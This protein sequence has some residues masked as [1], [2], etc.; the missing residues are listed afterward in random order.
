[1]KN[2]AGQTFYPKYL[3]KR[4]HCF[5][6]PIGCGK[7]I[8]IQEGPYRVPRGEGVEYETIAGFG[9]MCYVSSFEAVALANSLC[10]RYGLDTISTSAVIAFGMELFERGI[11]SL[12][13]TGGIELR[14]GNADAMLDMIHQIAHRQGLGAILAGGVREAARRIG[15]GAEQ[16]AIHVKG[17]EVAYHDPRAF[18]SMAVNYATGVR[19]ACHLEAAT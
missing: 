14:F 7:E 19:G 4:T 18:F 5:A 15:K 12:E 16:Y 1:V 6:C 3:Q 11:L 9:G 17:L 8:E 13:D 2:L 10:N